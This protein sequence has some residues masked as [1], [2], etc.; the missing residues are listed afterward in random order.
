MT[1]CLGKNC[2]FGVL[3]VFVM[4]VYQFYVS[5]FPFCFEGMMRNLIVLIPDHCLSICFTLGVW[6]KLI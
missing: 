2:S 6:L 1:T 4:N 3:S 5:S